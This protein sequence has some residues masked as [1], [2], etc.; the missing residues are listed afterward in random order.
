MKTLSSLA[1]LEGQTVI[2]RAG[3]DVPM[4]N[5]VITD[6]VRVESMVPTMRYIL[7]KGGALCIIA[8]QGR[9]TSA[10]E[11]E[12]SQ[13]PLIQVLESL[14]HTTVHFCESFDT[15]PAEYTPGSVTLFENLRYSDA[16]TSKDTHERLAF[17][18]KIAQHGTMYVNDAFTNCHRAHAS[19]VELAK[20]LPAYAGLSLEYELDHL[21]KIFTPSA[22][23]T[24]I[25]AGAKIETKVPV[26]RNLLSKADYVL[27]GGIIATSFL[28]A[29]GFHMGDAPIDA[30]SVSIATTLLEE[31]QTARAKLLF[32]VDV[33]TASSPDAEDV[34]IQALPF[35]A[36]IPFDIGPET[37]LQYAAA[38]ADSSVIVWN[39]PVGMY[40]NSAY[41]EGSEAIARSI[42]S[43][44][45]RSGF[46]VI[47]GGDTLDFW[48]SLQL[49]PDACSFASMAGGAMLSYL[50]GESMPGID[51][52]QA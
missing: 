52:L 43:A 9:P 51:V 41:R 47:G 12:F 48:N 49:P 36:G 13:R 7:D 22:K 31:A 35:A 24:C 3:F 10:C 44:T 8:H 14:L 37:R 2:V 20:I 11:A 21:S 16:E 45:E 1:S 25:I 15:V 28:Q 5:G 34:S 23:I 46:T 26:I 27:T 32:P 6:T 4:E 38:I 30:E 19:M 40:E 42:Q 39:G 18:K 17:A 33:V 50:A 29:K